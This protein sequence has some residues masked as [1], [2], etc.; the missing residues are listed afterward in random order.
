MID[1]AEGTHDRNPPDPGPPDP[2][3]PDPGP[4]D[5]GPPDPG[6]HERRQGSRAN[7][8][9]SQSERRQGSRAD[10][11]R[12]RS[13]RSQ[14]IR[15]TGAGQP[16]AEP[17]HAA[18]PEVP[19]APRAAAFAV[20]QAVSEQD[21]YANLVLPRQ[22]SEAGLTGRDAALGH[23][24]GLRHA[25]GHRHPGRGAAPVRQPRP[26]RHRTPVLNLLRLGAYQLLRTRIPP[27]RR[28]PPPSTWP[29]PPST[30]GRRASSTRCC[31]R[32]APATRRL[33]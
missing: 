11:A 1:L 20:L 28:W 3:P 19:D 31:A 24:T 4:P 22:L 27:T 17:S 8:G 10:P 23:P 13:G 18:V 30:P 33:V 15:L 7:P 29:G 32:S 14:G 25:A 9:R 6:P 5:P 12:A 16:G 26:G 2:G 21:A